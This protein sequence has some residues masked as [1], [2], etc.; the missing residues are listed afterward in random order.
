MGGDKFDVRYLAALPREARKA[1]TSRLPMSLQTGTFGP[2]ET[3]VISIS[4][5]LTRSNFQMNAN[6]SVSLPIRWASP[7]LN[8]RVTERQ[9]QESLDRSS[10][11][12]SVARGNRISKVASAKLPSLIHASP[13]CACLIK[14]RKV[15]TSFSFQFG[16]QMASRQ[17]TDAPVRSPRVRA[18]VVFPLPAHPRMTIR[19]MSFGCCRTCAVPMARRFLDRPT[20]KK[21]V[22][23]ILVGDNNRLMECLCRSRLRKPVRFRTTPNSSRD[24]AQRC[25][26]QVSMQGR[27]FPVRGGVGGADRKPAMIHLRDSIGSITSSISKCEAVLTALPC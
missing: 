19:A 1:A 3:L 2:C 4:G 18:K 8:T 27:F 23:P 15:G 25:F 11:I 14:V 12:T 13:A 9:A 17:I 22:V 26:Y 5:R 21:C 20:T 6:T 24:L 10:Q 16:C 7:R